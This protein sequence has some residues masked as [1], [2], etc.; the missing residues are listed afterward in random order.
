MLQRIEEKEKLRLYRL[1]KDEKRELIKRIKDILNE[2][3]EIIVA[4]IYGSFLEG[5]NFRDIDVAV[6][7]GKRINPLKYGAKLEKQLGELGFPFDVR[8][9][10][11]APPWFIKKVVETGLLLLDKEKII[12]ALHLAALE[13]LGLDFR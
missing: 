11:F 4:I 10:N 5:L 13:E 1:S 2:K 8:L 3:D 9:L 6:Y 12:D 7:V